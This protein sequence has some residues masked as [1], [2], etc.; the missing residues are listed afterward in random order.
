LE[1]TVWNITPDDVERVREELKGRRAAI[2]A[3]YDDEVQKLTAELDDIEAFERVATA[4]AQRHKREEAFGPDEP[5]PIARLEVLPIST[6]IGPATS[7]AERSD[8]PRLDHRGEIEALPGAEAP[9]V[10]ADASVVQK[11]SARWR[12]R[13]RSDA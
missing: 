8:H 9:P 12:I 11:A 1:L 3:R 2:Q 6:D 4:F 13:S 5:D 7:E 10:V